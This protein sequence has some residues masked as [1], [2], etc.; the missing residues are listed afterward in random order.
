MMYDYQSKELTRMFSSA[1]EGF[2]MHVPSNMIS[3]NA[4][5]VYL[6]GAAPPTLVIANHGGGDEEM[7]FSLVGFSLYNIK[8]YLAT[9][10]SFLDRRSNRLQTLFLLPV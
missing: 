4:V 1:D 6:K 3:E 7:N 2:A 8:D 9:G 5:M 10:M